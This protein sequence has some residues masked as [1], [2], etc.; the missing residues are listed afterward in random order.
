MS[1]LVTNRSIPTGC[2][3]C[4][5]KYDCTESVLLWRVPVTPARSPDCPLL[6][7]PEPHGRLVDADALKAFA[8]ERQKETGIACCVDALDISLAPTIIPAEE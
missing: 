3:D 2:I 7:V 4:W 8:Y 6:P 5:F 1:F